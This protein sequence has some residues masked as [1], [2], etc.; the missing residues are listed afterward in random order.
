MQA[1]EAQCIAFGRCTAT[2]SGYGTG[3]CHRR[4]NLKTFGIYIACIWQTFWQEAAMSGVTAT[5]E[6]E[7][8][9]LHAVAN[10]ATF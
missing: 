9:T 1:A 2:T 3:S 6:D 4:K 5:K 7:Q 8:A 10:N